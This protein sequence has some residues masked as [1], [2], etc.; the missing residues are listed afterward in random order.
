[1]MGARLHDLVQD[2]FVGMAEGREGV[3]RWHGR[4]VD[5]YRAC[6]QTSGGDGGD[7]RMET[8]RGGTEA[9]E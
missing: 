1:M 3:R 9:E 5:G 8:V 7:E 6:L 2:V 4:L